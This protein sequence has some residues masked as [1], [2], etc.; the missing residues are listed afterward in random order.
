MSNEWSP[1]VHKQDAPKLIK[2]TI[3][4]KQNSQNDI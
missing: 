1:T 4:T 3:M 2:E